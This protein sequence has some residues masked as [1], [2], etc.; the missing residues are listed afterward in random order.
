MIENEK[1]ELD[2][3]LESWEDDSKIDMTR[4]SEETSKIGSL[5]SKYLRY[6]S[7][8]SILLKKTT[9]G[10]NKLRKFK[11][12]YY[13]GKIPEEELK[14]FNIE[15]FKYILKTDIDKYIDGDNEIIKALNIVHYHSEIVKVCEYILKELSQRSYQMRTILDD[16]KFYSGA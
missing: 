3:V 16:Q 6:L 13:A 10:L 15:P 14:Q 9:G 5:H 1:T 2:I 12:R 11:W 7:K 4:I 8:H